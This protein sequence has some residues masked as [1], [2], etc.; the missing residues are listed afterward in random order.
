MSTN[1]DLDFAA[2]LS[3][4]I[5]KAS[6]PEARFNAASDSLMAAAAKSEFWAGRRD[7]AASVVAREFAI[8]FGTSAKAR[9]DGALA[10][11]FESAGYRGQSV[12]KWSTATGKLVES[13]GVD[14]IALASIHDKDCAC[15]FPANDVVDHNVILG[16]LRTVAGSVGCLNVA[17]AYDRLTAIRR[18]ENKP[19]DETADGD[20]STDDDA[21]T[22]KVAAIDTVLAKVIAELA[23]VSDMLK[24]DTNATVDPAQWVEFT[25]VAKNVA[26]HS[27]ANKGAKVTN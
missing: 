14:P 26:A 16:G 20:E 6:T 2:T 25:R 3:A 10:E 17:K 7:Y 8:T 12:A 15:T 23:R 11:L 24:A 9:R 5:D 27:N 4:R 18:E 21:P 19:K 1:V 22:V 13:F